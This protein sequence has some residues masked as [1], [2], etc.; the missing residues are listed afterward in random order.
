MSQ[1]LKRDR[2]VAEA[3]KSLERSA[4]RQRQARAKRPAEVAARVPGGGYEPCIVSFI[5]VLGF[6]DLLAT[7]AMP[8]TS[9]ISCFSFGSSQRRRTW[10]TRGS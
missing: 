8:T 9:A 5:D 4:A 7:R 3:L 1:K 10:R 6:R 2:T